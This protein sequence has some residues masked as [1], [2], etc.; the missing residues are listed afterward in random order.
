MLV[1]ARAF[2]VF[3][4]AHRASGGF[5]RS[6]KRREDARARGGGKVSAG[7]PDGAAP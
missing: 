3:L 4:F 6:A 1:V 5:V 7:A 2:L